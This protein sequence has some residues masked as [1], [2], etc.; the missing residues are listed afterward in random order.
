[1][2]SYEADCEQEKQKA[3]GSPLTILTGYECDYLKGYHSYF[4]DLKQRV[5]YLICGVHDLS[6]DLDQEYSVFYSN[7]TKHDLFR[8]TDMYCQALESGLFLFGA[9][10]DVFAHSYPKWDAEAKAASR[11]IIECAVSNNVALEINANGMRKRKVK[12]ESGLRYA[13]PLAEFWRMASEYPLKVVTNSDAHESRFLVDRQEECFA[14]ARQC[15][16][17]FSSY[18]LQDIQG[19]RSI[20]LA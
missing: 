3:S 16:V 5:D 8:Y 17:Q 12:G 1:M 6:P 14:F 19:K 20:T 4:E 10:P 15:S 18:L 11:A 2:S 9:H 13:Y 7:L